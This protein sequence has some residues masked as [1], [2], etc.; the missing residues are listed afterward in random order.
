[1]KR[2]LH[3]WRALLTRRELR[4]LSDY[5]L[6]DLGLSRAQIDSLFR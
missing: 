3:W 6:R 1:V 5:Q 4:E 2:I